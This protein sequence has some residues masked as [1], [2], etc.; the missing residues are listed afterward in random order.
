MVAQVVGSALGENREVQLVGIGNGDVE[1][2]RRVGFAKLL[3]P[4]LAVVD[5]GR[6][7][8]ARRAACIVGA[9]V[10]TSARRERV[11][12]CPERVRQVRVG[13]SEHTVFEALARNHEALLVPRLVNPV[14]A[15]AHRG[16]IRG[17][18]P[19]VDTIDDRILVELR[20]HPSRLIAMVVCLVVG[21]QL[22][23]AALEHGH[24][25][26][27]SF[28]AARPVGGELLH[29]I[30]VHRELHAVTALLLGVIQSDASVKQIVSPLQIEANVRGRVGIQAVCVRLAS[31]LET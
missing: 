7:V 1:A 17:K 14:V 31:D 26:A 4:L 20:V 16:V 28:L 3:G 27:L 29:A 25:E 21:N 22:Q 24:G 30:D 2:R 8:G 11:I 18:G 13:S 19:E 9:I 23:G 10:E 5:E 12:L 15:P 6:E